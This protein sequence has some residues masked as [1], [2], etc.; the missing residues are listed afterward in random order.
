M[1]I[2]FGSFFS[3][4]L[5]SFSCKSF[6]RGSELKS[7]KI[8]FINQ[9]NNDL[10]LFIWNICWAM[11]LS[12]TKLP[13]VVIQYVDWLGYGSVDFS[14]FF[15]Y[16][17]FFWT[18]LIVRHSCSYGNS[19][20]MSWRCV[21][22]LLPRAKDFSL[23]WNGCSLAAVFFS[24]IYFLHFV[25]CLEHIKQQ[26]RLRVCVFA[27]NTFCPEVRE[28]HEN[29]ERIKEKEN[30]L[31]HRLFRFQINIT[32]IPITSRLKYGKTNKYRI[33]CRSHSKKKK[34]TTITTTIA[35]CVQN[36]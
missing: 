36:K 29:L 10:Y 8:Y 26:R 3:T 2:V 32:S 16:Y 5:L 4:F 25:P 28:L 9:S 1:R 30:K 31:D 13:I 6:S 27:R 20:F 21:F 11:N 18:S 34:E 24:F 22:F 35:W 23:K 33:V 19:I 14:L 7:I 17:Y 15:F 12:C